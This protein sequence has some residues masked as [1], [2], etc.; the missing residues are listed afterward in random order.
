MEC[1]FAGKRKTDRAV[2]NKRQ[3]STGSDCKTLN[4]AHRCLD[5]KQGGLYIVQRH[6]QRNNGNKTLHHVYR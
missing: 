6:Q 5:K 4:S 1:S 3:N 2:I